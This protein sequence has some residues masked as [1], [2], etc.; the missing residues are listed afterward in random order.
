MEI[1]STFEHV[2]MVLSNVNCLCKGQVRTA[3]YSTS[4]GWTVYLDNCDFDQR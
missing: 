3:L 2:R 4:T 1:F